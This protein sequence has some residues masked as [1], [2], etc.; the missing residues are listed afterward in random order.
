MDILIASANVD[1]VKEIREMFSELN[2]MVSPLTEKIEVIEDGAT[3]FDNAFKKAKEISEHKN[4]IVLADDSGFEIDFL[5]KKPGVLTARFLGEKTSY[6]EKNKKYLELLSGVP[7]EKRTARATC[8]LVL[9]FPNGEFISST[10]ILEGLIS[11]TIRGDGGF[12]FDP[13][14]FVP[15]YNMTL[16]QMEKEFKNKISHRKKAL[17]GLIEK[18]RERGNG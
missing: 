5:D 14:F 6:E 9:Y 13:I 10:G 1:K 11:E 3:Y 4:K 12:G 8:A 18:L 17:D 16:G 15:E 2:H 7:T